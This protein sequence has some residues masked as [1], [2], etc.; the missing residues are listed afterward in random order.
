MCSSFARLGSVPRRS[1]VGVRQI[2]A[3]EQQADCEICERVGK[4]IAEIQLGRMAAAF[5]EIA[6]GVPRD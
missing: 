1:D 3:Y 6:I 4:A 5:A 2:V